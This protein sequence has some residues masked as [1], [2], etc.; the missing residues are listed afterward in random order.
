MRKQQKSKKMKKSFDNTEHSFDFKKKNPF[1]RFDVSEE[2]REHLDALAKVTVF[3]M[4]AIIKILIDQ[5]WE[6]ECG[7]KSE[8]G[9]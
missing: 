8:K 2:T 3:T 9:K 4:T 5:A 1:L 6:Q 7:N